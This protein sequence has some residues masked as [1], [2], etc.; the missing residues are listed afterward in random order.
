MYILHTIFAALFLLPALVASGGVCH[1]EC[2]SLVFD[3]AGNLAAAANDFAVSR[4]AHDDSHRVVRAE[5]LVGQEVFDTIWRRDAGGQNAVYQSIVGEWGTPLQR[6]GLYGETGEKPVVIDGNLVNALW[7]AGAA[8]TAYKN[9]GAKE[10]GVFSAEPTARLLPDAGSTTL[11]HGGRLIG[12]KVQS[13]SFSLTPDISYA[14]RYANARGG[15]VFKFEVPN[16]MLP[17]KGQDTIGTT[18]ISA[19][20]YQFYG[21]DSVNL[22]QYMR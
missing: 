10:V 1:G 3:E 20:V 9:L 6:I 11:Y 16:S 5:T 8:V 22:N 4:F 18:G 13:G 14:Q 15:V 17:I 7:D 19:P 12:G 2:G 21:A